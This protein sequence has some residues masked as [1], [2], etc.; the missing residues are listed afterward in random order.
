[1]LQ[2]ENYFSYTRQNYSYLSRGT[3][4]A[5]LK[6]WMRFF[7]KENILILRSEN[8][9]V[10][11]SKTFRQVLDFLNLPLWEPKEYKQH[12]YVPYQKIDATTRIRL[13]E[14]FKP[15]NHQLYD[16][17]GVNFNWDS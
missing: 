17:L 2:D 13:I 1:M 9:F 16:L 6:Q 3:Y 11:S 7:Q 8:F 12:H 4:V 14:Y 5:Q 15:Y 10:D